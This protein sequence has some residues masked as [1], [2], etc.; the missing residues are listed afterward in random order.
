MATD[1]KSKVKTKS[2]FATAA[3]FNENKDLATRLLNPSKELLSKCK[4]HNS[5]PCGKTSFFEEDKNLFLIEEEPWKEFRNFVGNECVSYLNECG[6]DTKQVKII[7][8]NAWVSEMYEGGSHHHHVHHPYCQV[9]G[10]FYVYADEGSSPL[11]FYKPEVWGDIWQS[12]PI[13]QKNILNIDKVEC[14]ART[15]L[16]AMWR[17]DV[18]HSVFHNKTKS[19]I[20]ISYNLVVTNV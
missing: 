16:N 17:S 4:D 6:I 10:N 5:Y 18:V 11:T 3:R 13:K 12:M 15:G 8:T 14:P 7:A 20:A 9:S 19:R 2:I 1:S